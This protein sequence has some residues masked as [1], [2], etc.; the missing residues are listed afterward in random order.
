VKGI[1][2]LV[3]VAV[4]A[5]AAAS[6][7]GGSKGASTTTTAAQPADPKPAPAHAPAKPSTSKS[8]GQTQANTHTSCPFAENVLSAYS[9]FVDSHHSAAETVEAYSPVTQHTYTL[10]C[11]VQQVLSAN[12]TVVCTEGTAR[13]SFPFP[14]EPE[15]HASPEEDQVGSTSHATD[16][17]FCDDHTCIGNFTTEGGAVVECSDGS[18]SHAGGIY[19][20]CSG[21]GG[22]AGGGG[23]QYEKEEGGT[24]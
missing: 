16:E 7:H 23:G 15:S 17:Q 10:A 5:I 8:C 3:I 19:G 4:V 9:A 6:S 13:V 14:Q 12:S 1:V 24:E 22:E 18:Y 20:A 21:H 11:K 2:L